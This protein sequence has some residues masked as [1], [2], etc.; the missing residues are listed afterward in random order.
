MR[1]IK[2]FD[3]SFKFIYKYKNI[4]IYKFKMSDD[5]ITQLIDTIIYQYDIYGQRK[6]MIKSRSKEEILS[7]NDLKELNRMIDTSTIGDVSTILD[8]VKDLH[9]INPKVFYKF[10]HIQRSDIGEF[11][12]EYGK[13]NGIKDI[14][15]DL[16]SKKQK[17][18]I[19]NDKINRI[20]Y[21]YKTKKL[22]A[23]REYRNII[24]DLDKQSRKEIINISHNQEDEVE[25]WT[26]LKIHA[27]CL[28]KIKD[29]T[30]EKDCD[31][32][33]KKI[34]NEK[35][36]K[37]CK[38]NICFD[39]KKDNMFNLIQNKFK[40][41]SIKNTNTFRDNENKLVCQ[42]CDKYFKTNRSYMR[43]L[44]KNDCSII[45]PV[46]IESHSTTDESEDEWDVI[47]DKECIEI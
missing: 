33:K 5:K 28:S 2:F 4:A 32:I 14:Y 29:K 19:M 37:K 9:Y 7:G 44:K 47:T 40:H 10:V 38:C 17:T 22:M 39:N 34:K 45:R 18:I 1:L 25:S 36:L 21:K 23:E 12:I 46:I 20:R 3:F 30:W 24:N 16:I 31:F 43:H 42:K 8:L 13:L 11:I 35:W 27:K 26:E 41:L 15:E 6:D